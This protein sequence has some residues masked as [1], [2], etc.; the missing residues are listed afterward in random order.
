MRSRASS[1]VRVSSSF[2][3]RCASAQVGK[4]TWESVKPGTTQRPPRSTTSGLASAVSWTPT[5]PTMRSPAIAS[6]RAVGSDGSSV[7]TTPFSRIT[8]PDSTEMRRLTDALLLG[9][10]ALVAGAAIVD[11]LEPSRSRVRP[12]R[13]GGRRPA[14]RAPARHARR[15][16]A[17][18]QPPRARAPVPPR[19]AARRDRLLR[20]RPPRARSPST[21]AVSSGTRSPAGRRRCCGGSSST[22]T[23]ADA[24]RCSA[25]RGSGTCA[26]PR[27]TASRAGRARR[28]PCSSARASSASWPAPWTST[29][30]A[31]ARAGDSSRPGR[32]RAYG[33]TTRSA[34]RLPVPDE[35]LR[36]GAVAWSPD[37]RWTVAAADDHLAVFRTRSRDVAAR[38]PVG[39]VDVDWTATRR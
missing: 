18:L 19:A 31:R 5:P 38:I 27:P 8:V 15:R 7:R 17:G 16:R 20:L 22:A 12:G 2:T 29:T 33:C 25:R 34:Q 13:R 9:A 28:S 35:V 10:V 4:W 32:S 24:R 1:N 3:S 30:S 36:A 14:R 11:A 23:S 39:G 26:T 37:E 6:A 21:R